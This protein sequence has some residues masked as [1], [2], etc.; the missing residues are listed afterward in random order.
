VS[1]VFAASLIVFLVAEVTS[2][3]KL[4]SSH[5]ILR[6]STMAVW[7][8]VP[9]LLVSWLLWN[10]AD[11]FEFQHTKVQLTQLMK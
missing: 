2:A 7:C 3:T 8:V 11:V 6:R 10:H 1:V 4:L 5:A 9:L